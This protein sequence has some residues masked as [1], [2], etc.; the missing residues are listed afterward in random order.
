MWSEG[1]VLLL[2]SDNCSKRFLTSYRIGNF[3]FCINC[4]D[5]ENIYFHHFWQCFRFALLR[6]HPIF[7]IVPPIAL[8]ERIAMK[9]KNAMKTI[10]EKEKRMGRW[11]TYF[12]PQILLETGYQHNQTIGPFDTCC[13]LCDSGYQKGF[14]DSVLDVT[15]TNRPIW[16]YCHIGFAHEN[17]RANTLIWAAERGITLSEEK[18]SFNRNAIATPG[19]RGMQQHVRMMQRAD[20]WSV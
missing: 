5:L 7:T 8:W 2:F 12:C 1:Q 14:P 19:M 16:D 9:K 3:R 10:K 13:R 11:W 17:V 18:Y 20:T 4:A 15:L 6:S